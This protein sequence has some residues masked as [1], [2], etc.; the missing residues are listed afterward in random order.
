MNKYSTLIDNFVQQNQNI[1]G[2]NLIGVYLHGSAVMGCFNDQK[3]DLDFIVVI[4][5]SLSKSAKRCYMD[6]VINLNKQAPKKGIE[7]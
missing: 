1:L 2:E 3:S 5:N 4:K 7:L 6:M